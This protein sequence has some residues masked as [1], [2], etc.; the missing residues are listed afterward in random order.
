MGA[1][2]GDLYPGQD[3]GVVHGGANLA[4]AAAGLLGVPGIIDGVGQSPALLLGPVPG[5]FVEAEGLAGLERDHVHKP[6]AL[7]DVDIPALPVLHHRLVGG[8][9]AGKVVNGGEGG[10]LG[11]GLLEACHGHRRLRHRHS[12]R[13]GQLIGAALQGVFDLACHRR[14]IKLHAIG[15]LGIRKLRL[16]IGG[17][18]HGVGVIFDGHDRVGGMAGH[19]VVEGGEGLHKIVPVVAH[20][21]LD[22]GA[23]AGSGG[24][25]QGLVHIEVS[26][27]IPTGQ[28][29]IEVFVFQRDAH[30]VEL[31][32]KSLLQGGT[33]GLHR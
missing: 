15:A 21:H 31:L 30:A 5:F 27:Y 20:E 16:L 7:A 26:A 4:N 14:R 6:Y 28:G 25:G 1:M 18:A 17:L 29:G 10:Q 9:G 12:G 24:L 13:K 3:Q 2:I 8:A 33:S 23:A 22:G 32:F 19:V 11:G